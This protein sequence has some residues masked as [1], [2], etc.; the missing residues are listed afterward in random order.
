[1]VGATMA[2]AVKNTF[3]H[4]VEKDSNFEVAE[5][6]DRPA[7]CLKRALTQPAP[8]RDEHPCEMEADCTS[9][10]ALPP[11][12]AVTQQEEDMPFLPCVGLRHD[13]MRVYTSGSIVSS[14]FSA[15][16]M[17]FPLHLQPLRSQNRTCPFLPCVG[18]RQGMMRVDTSG[19]LITSNL[20]ALTMTLPFHRQSLHSRKRTSPFLPCVGL[21]QE[22]MRVDTSGSLL[23][24]DLRDCPNVQRQRARRLTQRFLCRGLRTWQRKT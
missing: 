11:S 19:S 16:P 20:S 24:S 21:R 7:L 2:L 14:N 12:A 22:R 18:L 3:I 1:M 5:E 23:A 13:M 4:G 10:D 15:I 8:T 9:D 17:M 6:C